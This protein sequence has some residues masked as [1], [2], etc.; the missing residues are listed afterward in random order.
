MEIRTPHKGFIPFQRDILDALSFDDVNDI[1]SVCDYLDKMNIRY[2]VGWVR[3]TIKGLIESDLIDRNDTNRIIKYSL[4]SKAI[5][6]L[7]G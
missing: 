1:N 5:L 2:T 7:G 3:K 4:T 6:L